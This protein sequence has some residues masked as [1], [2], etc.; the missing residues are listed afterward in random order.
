MNDQLNLYIST[1]KNQLNLFI[2]TIKEQWI[3]TFPQLKTS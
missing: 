3:Y 1:I 2:S